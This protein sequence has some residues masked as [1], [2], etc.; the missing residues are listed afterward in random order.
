MALN[1]V[2]L[3]ADVNTLQ[4]TL[5]I[6]FKWTCEIGSRESDE[7]LFRLHPFKICLMM[8]ECDGLP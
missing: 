7:A 1:N 6:A 4:Y 5:A 2:K 3:K 8:K